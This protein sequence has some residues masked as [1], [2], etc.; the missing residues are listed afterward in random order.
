[1]ISLK[2][3]NQKVEKKEHV[4]CGKNK[5]KTAGSKTHYIP[6]KLD[7]QC[8]TLRH[9]SVKSLKLKK[10]KKKKIDFFTNASKKKKVSDEGEEAGRPQTSAQ[11]KKELNPPHSM[12]KKVRPKN[13]SPSQ[14]DPR[15]MATEICLTSQNPSGK[16]A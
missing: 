4:Y 12:G 16:P 6:E 11:K 1:M 10:K 3:G 13:I 14:D 2:K 5:T 7:S 8:L 15:V 9:I